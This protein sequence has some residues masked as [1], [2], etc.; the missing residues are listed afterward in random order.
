MR[1]EGALDLPAIDDLGPGPAF[2]RTRTIIGQRDAPNRHAR[3]RPAGS[4]DLLTACRALRPWP[5]ASA[6]ARDPREIG[7]PPVAAKKLLQLLA[8]DA[9]E[10]G[11]IGN[12]VSVEMQDRDHPPSVAGSRNLLECHAVASGPVS[13]SPSPTTHGPRNPDCRTPRRKRGS[14][15][16]RARRPRGSS[17]GIP[18]T[19]GWESRRETKTA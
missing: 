18:A 5:R 19:R 1:P 6:P 4:S 16:S 2:G 17:P 13:A 7:R 12:L 14:A 10:D 9:G 3:A 15:N 11:G 8:G